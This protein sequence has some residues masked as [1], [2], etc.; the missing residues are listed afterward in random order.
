MK[1]YLKKIIF[2]KKKG[3]A[4]KWEKSVLTFQKCINYKFK[5]I[6]FL[7]QSL[8]HLS[9]KHPK[10]TDVSPFERMEFFGDSILGFF[11]SE[12][13][14]NRYPNKNEGY[15]SKIKSKLVSEKYLAKVAKEI[16]L[17]EYILLSAN[18]IRNGG[19]EKNSILSD[20]L[21]ALVCSIYL[22][23]GIK[24]TKNFIKEVILKNYE[25]K[26]KMDYLRYQEPPLYKTVMEKGPDHNKTFIVEVNLKNS[27][28]GKGEG[29]T[30]KLAQQN[31]AKRVWEKLK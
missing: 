18:E 20:S 13:L 7:K 19:R 11:V 24:K 25:T 5:D 16:K 6:S 23:G 1:R 28:K 17:S 31:A 26:I 15:L 21:E 4:S 2:G 9:Y 8:T 27:V 10:K 3:R 29:T 12:I 30:K 22:D 14:F